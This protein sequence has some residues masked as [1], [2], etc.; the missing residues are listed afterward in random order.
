MYKLKIEYL[1]FLFTTFLLLTKW[2]LFILTD[3]ADLQ[4]CYSA[5]IIKIQL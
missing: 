4:T 2:F 1:L 3:P 5:A